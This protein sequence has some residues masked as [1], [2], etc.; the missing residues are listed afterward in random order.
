MR[1]IIITCSLL[2]L[3]NSVPLYMFGTS[4]P[5]HFVKTGIGEIS[6]VFK[7]QDTKYYTNF[8]FGRN[9]R[10]SNDDNINQD[11]DYF[12]PAPLGIFEKIKP[13]QPLEINKLTTENDQFSD[14]RI[15]IKNDRGPN[16][17]EDGPG[18]LPVELETNQKTGSEQDPDIYTLSPDYTAETTEYEITTDSLMNR[19]GGS[20]AAVLAS[21]LGPG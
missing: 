15:P 8:T 18:S 7:T 13:Q 1:L 11:G 4:A 3:V 5:T 16:D 10:F 9:N 2:G 14:T 20:S 17:S 21:L 6:Q 19:V 12:Y